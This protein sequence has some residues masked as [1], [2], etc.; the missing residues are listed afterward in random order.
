MFQFTNKNLIEK[1]KQEKIKQEKIK[2]YI[3]IILKIVKFLN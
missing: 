3:T 2:K 1:I